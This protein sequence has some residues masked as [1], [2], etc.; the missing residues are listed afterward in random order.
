MTVPRA[1]SSRADSSRAGSRAPSGPIAGSARLVAP[2]RGRRPSVSRDQVLASALH[3]VEADGLAALTMRDLARE[4]GVAVGTVYA[5]A[6]SKEDILQGLADTVLGNLAELPV[7]GL[8]WRDA[9]VALFSEWHR[10]MLDHPAI[11]Q[12]SVLEPLVGP[13]ISAGQD[14]IFTIIH[15]AGFDQAEAITLF[16]TLSSYTAGYTL[17][18]IARPTSPGPRDRNGRRIEIGLTDEQFAEGLR[19]VLGGF[20]TDVSA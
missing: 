13:G 20:T 10:L 16:T 18:Q 4:L 5:A 1:D 9:L 19:K 3:L 7:T 2:R 8:P 11:A 6:G 12:L 17:C 15:A 14:A